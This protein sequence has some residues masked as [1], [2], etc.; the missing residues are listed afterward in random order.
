MKQNSEMYAVVG[1][2]NVALQTSFF[3]SA[4][5]HYDRDINLFQN[6]YKLLVGVQYCTEWFVSSECD[7][8]MRIM[9]V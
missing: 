5:K 6:L 8:A 4:W 9:T 7:A 2:R 1:D 3:T